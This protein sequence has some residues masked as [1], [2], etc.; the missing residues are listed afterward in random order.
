MERN[1]ARSF[2]Y[3]KVIPCYFCL[4]SPMVLL[5][6]AFSQVPQ[7]Q[8]RLGQDTS[9]HGAGGCISSTPPWKE[10]VGQRPGRREGGGGAGF[11]CKMTLIWQACSQVS[12]DAVGKATAAKAVC[13]HFW[14]YADFFLLPIFFF[15]YMGGGGESSQFPWQQCLHLSVIRY[16]PLPVS[17]FLNQSEK[18]L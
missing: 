12:T 10:S 3:K 14:W 18:C 16:H 7:Q 13:R 11:Y 15:K 17:K 1:T 6:W 8:A 9:G 2:D 4:L 5:L